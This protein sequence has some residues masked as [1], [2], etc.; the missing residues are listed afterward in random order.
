MEAHD[1]SLGNGED[2]VSRVTEDEQR[3]RAASA[4]TELLRQRAG[5]T[6]CPSE[7]AR[8]IGGDDWR[9][10]MP[11]VRDVAADLVVQGR[12]IVQQKGKTVDIT[13]ARGPVR[14]ARGPRERGGGG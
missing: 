13:T 14:L 2:G 8:A 12:V 10:L 4:I 7:A 6:I 3:E 11:L 5:K 9:E 1:G